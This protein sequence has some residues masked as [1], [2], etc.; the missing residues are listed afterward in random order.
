MINMFYS[1]FVEG[2]L[3]FNTTSFAGLVMQNISK[4]VS[5]KNNNHSQCTARCQSKQ[6]GRHLQIQIP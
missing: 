1:A 4:S 2:I 6:P 3:T 5:L